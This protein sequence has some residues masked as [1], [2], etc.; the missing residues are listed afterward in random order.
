MERARPPELLGT[1]VAVGFAQCHVGFG[2]PYPIEGH[3]TSTTSILTSL[4]AARR[5]VQSL[6]L[7]RLSLAKTQLLLVAGVPDAG[8]TTVLREAS[9]RSHRRGGWSWVELGM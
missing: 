9:E 2:P 8:K 4:Q 6:Q 3:A 7:Q 5:V 1:R